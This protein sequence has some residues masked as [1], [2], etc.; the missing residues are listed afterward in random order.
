MFPLSKQLLPALR[1]YLLKLFLLFRSQVFVSLI[2][3]LCLY[4]NCP[5][6]LLQSA[7]G[8]VFSQALELPEFLHDQRGELGL[9]LFIEL[10]PLTQVAHVFF[11]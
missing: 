5:P 7:H 3:K 9:L 11:R 10:Q 6:Q 4:L 8:R 1:L 2:A